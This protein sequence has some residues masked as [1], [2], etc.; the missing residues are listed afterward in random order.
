M[1]RDRILKI[2]L[3]GLL[4]LAFAAFVCFVMIRRQARHEMAVGQAATEKDVY[5]CPMH[6]TYSISGRRASREA[7]RD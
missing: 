4:I 3:V 2:S 7:A 5:Y 1:N 6:K